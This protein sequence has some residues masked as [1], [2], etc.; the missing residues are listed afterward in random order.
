MFGPERN[1]VSGGETVYTNT[2][3]SVDEHKNRQPHNK[4]DTRCAKQGPYRLKTINN[5]MK[6]T[7]CGVRFLAMYNIT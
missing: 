6:H 7:L 2:D 4:H 3:C 1:A 5:C